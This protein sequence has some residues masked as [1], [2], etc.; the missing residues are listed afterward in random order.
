MTAKNAIRMAYRTIRNPILCLGRRRAF[1]V[2]IGLIWVLM[3]LSIILEPPDY[4]LSGVPH[5]YIPAPVRFTLWVASGGVAI[6][7]SLPGVSTS[8]LEAIGFA[9]LYI[10]PAERSLSYLVSWVSS[11]DFV[12]GVGL[13]K[14]WIFFLQYLA[15]V[16]VISITAGWAEPRKDQLE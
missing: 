7:A 11:F 3:G 6:V 4:P 16:G 2:L 8:R 15:Y 9:A 12:P 14:G 5:T 13:T 1:L 10:M